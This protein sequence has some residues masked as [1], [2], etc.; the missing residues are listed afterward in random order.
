MSAEAGLALLESAPRRER[1]A[2]SGVPV[3]L[4][5]ADDAAAAAE[6]GAAEAHA[7]CW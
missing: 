2:R 5:A 1:S 7:V 4:A 6:A 3:A